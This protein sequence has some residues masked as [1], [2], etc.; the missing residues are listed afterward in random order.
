[1][2]LC[3]N[4]YLLLKR[5]KGRKRP[6]LFTPYDK[7]GDGPEGPEVFLFAQSL[8]RN[9]QGKFLEN[10]DLIG[11][12]QDGHDAPKNFEDLIENLPSIVTSVT[13]KGKLLIFTLENGYFLYSSLGMTGHWS[14]EITKH[15][16]VILETVD[17][18]I[19]YTDS[20]RFGHFRIS[21]DTKIQDDIAP[22]IL[23]I[24]KEEYIKRAGKYKGWLIKI[25]ID[26][27][28]ICSGVG[29]Y[30]LSEIVYEGCYGPDD[31]IE[32]ITDYGMMYDITHKL[33][34]SSINNGGASL[35][36]YKKYDGKNG[37]FQTML[38]AYG[39]KYDPDNN[40]IVKIKG[41]HGRTLWIVDR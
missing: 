24:T 33:V 38:K 4:Q 17:K 39:R 8:N 25:L 26:Q 30:L 22:S 18:S 3:K 14:E 41:K 11:K 7:E 29:N 27:R 35:Q 28:K 32:E 1:M 16:H 40:P 2:T 12:Y 36:N 31:K 37:N 9:L 21:K 20:R 15:T 19:S 13:S 6:K 10:V 34:Q 5:E 23:D